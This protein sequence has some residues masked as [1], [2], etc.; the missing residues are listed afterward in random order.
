MI[1]PIPTCP[2]RV[3]EPIP[4]VARV[5]GI[6]ARATLEHEL[7]TR[8]FMT[9][10][11]S[12]LLVPFALFLLAFGSGCGHVVV[13]GF[14]EGSLWHRG[15]EPVMAIHPLR[16]GPLGGRA[17]PRDPDLVQAKAANCRPWPLDEHVQVQV[18]AAQICIDE[19][20]HV[21]S[22]ES[23][24][25]PMPRLPAE[26]EASNGQ[27]RKVELLSSSEMQKV[28]VCTGLDS[29]RT[30]VWV[31]RYRA[32][33]PNDGLVTEATESLALKKPGGLLSASY[34]QIKWGF[35]KTGAPPPASLRARGALERR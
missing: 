32:C 2:R 27:S 23:G 19:D 17:K 18:T 1:A 3:I 11:L 20:V 34:E 31:A 15:A 21:L 10:R 9:S 25:L 4:R 30:A 29:M 35:A 12:A 33:V 26:L 14:G 6:L 24:A 13:G 28:G 22:Y 8:R 16:G 7:Q 5:L